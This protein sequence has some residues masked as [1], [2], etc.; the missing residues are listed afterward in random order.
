MRVMM[1]VEFNSFI[2]EVLGRGGERKNGVS[3]NYIFLP[4]V[5]LSA[6]HGS[7]GSNFATIARPSF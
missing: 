6:E 2:E 4:T 3:N 7:T 1:R 5:F